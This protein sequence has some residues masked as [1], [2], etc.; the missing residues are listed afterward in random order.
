[1]SFIY[2]AYSGGAVFMQAMR[3]RGI[4]S[5]LARRE[6]KAQQDKML[7]TL[8]D[9]RKK[10]REHYA[11]MVEKKIAEEKNKP[12]GRLRAGYL[13]ATS[14]IYERILD[15]AEGLENR[16]LI[17][18]L[19]AGML[20]E[21]SRGYLIR[22]QAYNLTRDPEYAKKHLDQS[23]Y[24]KQSNHIIMSPREWAEGFAKMLRESSGVKKAALVD[25]LARSPEI[26]GA[27]TKKWVL[28]KL[29]QFDNR[30]SAPLSFKVAS[31]TSRPLS[32]SRG[33]KPNIP[34]AYTPEFTVSPWRY[35]FSSIQGVLRD[36]TSGDLPTLMYKSGEASSIPYIHTSRDVF[37]VGR[38]VFDAV[39]SYEQ[40][41]RSLSP[42]EKSSIGETLLNKHVVNDLDPDKKLIDSNVV[43]VHSRMWWE[44]GEPRIISFETEK[45]SMNTIM[46]SLEKS[47]A[48][49]VG[50]GVS[51]DLTVKDSQEYRVLEGL[52]DKT[53]SLSED[54]KNS[55]WWLSGSESKPETNQSKSDGRW[56]E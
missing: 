43:E 7:K 26:G 38:E 42:E 17:G 50:A 41:V 18:R 31:E 8:V 27:I 11:K 3:G 12:L 55:F 29:G 34:Y 54:V 35:R 47:G 46:D 51:R 16:G 21:A 10:N 5:I 44:G 49:I 14:K 19:G 13:R 52:E 25:Q 22:Q 28:S 32:D 39:K 45:S 9:E 24:V 15:K 2:Q 1:A 30:I 20:R 37:E 48:E 23:I 36:L 40:Y 56:W 6:A 53:G 33:Y 4:P